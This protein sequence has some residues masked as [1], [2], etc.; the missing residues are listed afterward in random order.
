MLHN[1]R[2]PLGLRNKVGKKSL[3]ILWGLWDHGC[4]Q[5][6]IS[7]SILWDPYSGS[8]GGGN[9]TSNWTQTAVKRQEE[10]EEALSQ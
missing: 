9:A 6:M 5:K 1:L 4:V 7:I 10:E 2:P 8:E 3:D